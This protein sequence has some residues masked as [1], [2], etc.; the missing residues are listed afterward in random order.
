MKKLL[1]L[2]LIISTNAFAG[3]TDLK[4]ST[5]QIFDVQWNISGGKLNA[6]GFNY[7][8][9][10]INYATQTTSAA[11]WTAAQTADAASNGRYIG[12]FNSTTNPGT[13]GMAVYNSDGSVYK[14]INNTG[15]FRTLADGAIFYNGNGM[16]GTLITTKQGYTY[17][18]SASFTI[19]QEYPTNAQ[20]EAY[21]PD[22][23]T[24]L[25]AGET[26]EPPPPPPPAYS[27]TITNE[28]QQRLNAA[29]ARQTY[30]NEVNIDQIGNYN[31][32]EVIQS[33]FYQ[34]VDVTVIGDSNIVDIGQYGLKNY[35]NV[36][37][38]GSSNTINSYQANTGALSPGHFSEMLI[39]GN[40]N[41][42]INS[43]TGDGE[44]INFIS[45]DGNSN[46]VNNTQIG[47][48]TKYS[49]IK[50]VGNDH[51]I[52]INQKDGGQ[53]AARIEVTN[54]GGA[55]NINVLQQG[56][57]NQTYSIQQSCAT[58]GGCSVTMTQQ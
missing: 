48:T 50:T 1:L 39:S 34:L 22:S 10:S 46:T 31:N 18:Q 8:Y 15:S 58:V 38:Q 29:R 4:L 27:A 24:P 47:N 12:F 36:Q 41:S 14:L 42:I 45:V 2:L 49:D 28:Q 54:N 20:L 55:S 30:K 26:A 9:S 5:A 40:N 13:Y 11:R 35:A 17:G 37:A 56:N 7:I 23:T 33:G 32:I 51:S 44:K 53:H 57:T 6:S 21:T 16:W 19:T 43:Q 25:A 3:I 52:I